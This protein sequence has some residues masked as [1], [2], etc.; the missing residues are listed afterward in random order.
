M[1]RRAAV[2]PWLICLTALAAVWWACVAVS[3]YFTAVAGGP[4]RSAEDFRKRD[5][6]T[7]QAGDRTVR[8]LR[9]G[10]GK[11]EWARADDGSTSC[12]DDLGFDDGDVTRKQP[13]YVWRLSYSGK[14][15]YMTDLGKLREAWEDRGLKV[16]DL[17]PPEQL[18]PAR[19]L[20]D[21]P[22][23]RTTDEHGV[24]IRMNLNR[25]TGEPN[26][27]TDGGCVRY[28]RAA[29]V[30]ARTREGAAGGHTAKEGRVVYRD[31]TEVT[32]G[33]VQP[34]TP[35]PE[36][37]PPS[38]PTPAHAYRVTVT[39]TNKSGAALELRRYETGAWARTNPDLTELSAYTT[40]FDTTSPTR[41]APGETTHFEFA[42]AAQEKPPHL[43]FAFGPGDLHTPYTWRLAVR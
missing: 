33:A 32:I 18:N 34:F 43:D 10:A 20:P 19:P 38:T 29:K 36:M 37:L 39:V 3:D 11:P 28:D 5:I 13:G 2:R 7:R 31:G 1:S 9:P 30:T 35:T 24:A 22:G 17:P 8:A 26:V 27:T 41:V 16:Q 21:W 4:V 12:V 40:G 42:Y 23:I 14:D 25:Y 15:A 6:A